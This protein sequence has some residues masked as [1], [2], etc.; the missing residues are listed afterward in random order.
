MTKLSLLT[1]I[2]G[3]AMALTTAASK[4]TEE[5]SLNIMRRGGSDVSQYVSSLYFYTCF[6][7]PY[8]SQICSSL[9]FHRQH[10]VIAWCIFL[11]PP[12]SIAFSHHMPRS[13]L[14]ILYLSRRSLR[15]A[16]ARYRSK[17]LWPI[18]TLLMFLNTFLHSVPR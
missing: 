9:I 18:Y 12:G 17:L 4:K 1:S 5:K 10:I 6:W 8:N 2:T 14:S 11:M 7:V 15:I 3:S 16:R 13:Y